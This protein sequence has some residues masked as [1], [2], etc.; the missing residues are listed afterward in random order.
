M[1]AH[2]ICDASHAILRNRSP[3][4]PSLLLII[5]FTVYK[6][7]PRG[8]VVVGSTEKS[9]PTSHQVLIEVTRSGHCGADEHHVP[10]NM[11]LGHEG[12][13]MVEL[14]GESVTSVKLQVIAILTMTN[15]SSTD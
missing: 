4:I 9:L 14:V 5:R 7:P 8:K 11:V 6:G 2:G 1:R 12:F 13:G 15:L 10:Q 3:Y